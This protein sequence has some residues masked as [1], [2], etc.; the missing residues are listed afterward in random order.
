MTVTATTDRR[1]PRWLLNVFRANLVAQ[2]GIVL[3]GG[4]VRLTGSGLGCPTWPECVD[5]S[6]LPTARQE[7]SWHKMVEFG[8]RTLTF[9]LAALAIAAVVG[10]LLW[11]RRLRAAG[12]PGRRPLVLLAAI[13]LIGTVVQAVLGGITV[14][15]GLHPA[16]VAAHFLVSIGIIAGVAVLVDRAHDDGDQPVTPVVRTALRRLGDVLV[17]LALVI[18][19]LGTIVTGSGPNSGDADVANRFGLEQQT[20]AWVHAD[21]VFLFVGMLV[22]LLLAIHLVAAP[23][24]VRR[25]AWILTGLTV[26]NGTVGY[27]QIATGLPW[28]AVGIHMLLACLIWVAV[29]RVRLAMRQRGTV[30]R[31]APAIPTEP[32]PANLPQ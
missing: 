19:T 8:N 11:H 17:V 20:V 31:I 26:A 4:L 5:G 16:V 18:I 9:I 21:T 14:L 23:D 29:I 24:V 32:Q 6:L 30:N 2:V 7:E 22:G 3:T 12:T 25:R 1:A 28:L 13:P 27:L 15:T 10:A